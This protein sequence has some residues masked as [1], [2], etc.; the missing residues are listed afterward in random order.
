MFRD[1]IVDRD[2]YNFLKDNLNKNKK[3]FKANKKVKLLRRIFAPV[4]VW[5]INLFIKKENKK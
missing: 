3:Y 1:K 5:L 4:G 2:S